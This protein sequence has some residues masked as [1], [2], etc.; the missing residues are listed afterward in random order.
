MKI[1]RYLKDNWVIGF[2]ALLFG[3]I[4][5]LLLRGFRVNSDLCIA[6]VG[7]YLMLWLAIVIWDYNRKNRFYKKSLEHTEQLDKKYLVLETLEKPDFY[8]GELF[9]QVLYEVNK[10][11]CEHVKEYELSINDFK[12]YLEMWVHEAK[13][14]IASMQL[15]CHN[16]REQMDKRF[17]KQ[18]RRLDQ[19][20]EQVL[21]YVRSEHASQDYLIK[22][23]ELGSVVKKVV[24]QNK[25][26]LLERNI[27]IQVRDVAVRVLTDAKWLEF[28]MNQLV[29]NAMKYMD[30]KKQARLEIYAEESEQHCYLHIRDN[31]IGIPKT[32][33]LKV[34]QKSFTGKNGRTSAKSTGMGLYIVKKLCEN[35]GHAIC[36]ESIEGEYTDVMITFS[37]NDFYKVS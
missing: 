8:E 36:L 21:Y 30:E 28:M 26:E 31:G 35:L 34:F 5:L 24:M 7:L 13:L 14:P 23:V 32:D 4:F 17:S 10:S 12:E 27:E 15:M 9:Y 19:Y 3:G 11:M 16:N 25:D 33:V 1:Q 29:N 37:Q 18:L 22:E 6:F 20:T 2:A